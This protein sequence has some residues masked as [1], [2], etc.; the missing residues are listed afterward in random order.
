MALA[1]KKDRA[2]LRSNPSV[3]R[4]SAEGNG[5]FRTTPFYVPAHSPRENIS[6]KPR[7]SGGSAPVIEC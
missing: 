7:G 5:S 4:D 6:D 1:R 3:L 2:M